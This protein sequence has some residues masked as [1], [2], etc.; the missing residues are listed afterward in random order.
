MPPKPQKDTAKGAPGKGR[1]GKDGAQASNI[2]FGLPPTVV[3]ALQSISTRATQDLWGASAFQSES[4]SAEQIAQRRSNQ[5]GKLSKRISGDTKAKQ[6]LAIAVAEWFTQISQHLLGLLGRMRALGSKIDEDLSIAVQEMQQ[7]LLEQ[8]STAT[9]EQLTAAASV[10]GPIWAPPQEQEVVKLAAALRAFGVTKQTLTSVPPSAH[11][12]PASRNL[13]QAD[14]TSEFSFGGEAGP[15]AAPP[16][17]APTGSRWQK[18]RSAGAGTRPSKS[19]RRAVPPVEAPWRSTVTGRTPEGTRREPVLQIEEDDP[20]LLPAVDAPPSSA[21]FGYWLQLAAF[22]VEHGADP[23]GELSTDEAQD[24]AFP[25]PSTSEG[26]QEIL[27]VAETTW[28]ELRKVVREKS[29]NSM[30]PVCLALHRVLHSLRQSPA[31]LPQVRQGLLLAAH[32]TLG[33]LLDPYSYA[34]ATAQEWLHPA[35]LVEQGGPFKGYLA[36]AV[37]S[38]PEVQGLL[39]HPCPYSTSIAADHTSLEA[40]SAT[41]S[42]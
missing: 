22:A 31:A 19:P 30:L 40:A 35:S 29:E 42:T 3:T 23:V 34:P 21:W 37:S 2:E 13:M 4:L 15:L 11:M 10:M 12:D 38:A 41:A 36:S 8:P 14:Q 18:R 9:E 16:P 33:N 20:E 27:Q 25:L 24:A 17:A 28:Q 6:D 26:V 1:S 5:A 32:V 39:Q 7:Y